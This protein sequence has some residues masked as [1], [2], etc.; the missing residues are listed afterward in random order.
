L[1]TSKHIAFWVSLSLA[2]SSIQCTKNDDG[3]NFIYNLEEEFE[4]SPIEELSRTGS[5]L[6]L[7]IKS[8]HQNVCNSSEI[9]Y[10]YRVEDGVALIELD[11]IVN[12]SP[13]A[14]FGDPPSAHVA[15]PD[16]SGT[17]QPLNITIKEIIE[18]PG[19]ISEFSAHYEM[20]MSS[21][22]GIRVRNA[23][24]QK[25]QP[26]MI[27]GG[28]DY[29]G[30]N[31]NI[32]PSAFYDEIQGIAQGQSIADGYYGHFSQHDNEIE[33]LVDGAEKEFRSAFVFNTNKTLTDLTDIVQEYSANHPEM[34]FFLYNAFGERL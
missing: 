17:S 20:T 16:M 11:D 13:C 15:M 28:V 10:Q 21:T 24:L 2:L 31:N 7:N 9:L 1:N 33:L 8:L 12:S 4:V 27:W 34:R 30:N 3:P 6:A 14:D 26:T 25:I 23:S 18:N 29:D 22:N 19:E 5:R 32:V